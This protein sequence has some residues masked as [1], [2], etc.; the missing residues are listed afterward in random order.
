[1]LICR[2]AILLLLISICG[3]CVDQQPPSTEDS[4]DVAV[5][6][7]KQ[8]ENQSTTPD[9]LYDWHFEGFSEI[10]AYRINWD[11][12]DSETPIVLRDGT[13][14]P[15]RTPKDGL[16]LSNKQIGRLQ[17]AL[18][19]S[20]PEHEAAGCI[21]PHHAFVFFSNDGRIVGS[22]NICFLCDNYYGIPRGFAMPWDL[23]GLARLVR[24]LGMPISNP[25]WK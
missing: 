20:H 8:V 10:R 24:D 16:R 11:E 22:V 12:E 6:P 13:L 9:K 2:R 14:N 19:G 21:Y 23:D 7:E 18:Y 3:G 1:M 4:D 25:N 15:T 17:S 5:A